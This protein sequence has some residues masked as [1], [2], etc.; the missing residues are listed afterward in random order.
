MRRWTSG[1]RAAKGVGDGSDA[2]RIGVRRFRRSVAIVAA[3]AI[4][5]GASAA[6]EPLARPSVAKEALASGTWPAGGAGS[7]LD[8]AQR[9]GRSGGGANA[10]PASFSAE[11]ID[12]SDAQ[13]VR[14]DRASRTVG[15]AYDGS[16]Q[17]AFTA[18]RAGLEGKGWRCIESGVPMVATFVK[19]V[20]AYRWLALSCVQSG[21]VSS[22]VVQYKLEDDG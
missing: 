2:G 9:T 20:G 12:V 3:G 8:E 6:V 16:S 21:S 5:F 18:C 11:V 4:A 14:F 10:P 1:P 22:V 13:E 17:D 15:F 19:P 7:L